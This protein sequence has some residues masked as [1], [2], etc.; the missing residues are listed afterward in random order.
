MGKKITFAKKALIDLKCIC[1]PWFY[2]AP[3]PPPSPPGNV[4]LKT[5]AE[6]VL[7]ALTFWWKNEK[8]PS[9]LIELD[10]EAGNLVV[11]LL[12]LLNY[13]YIFVLFVL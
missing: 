1:R 5:I 4:L 10:F 7:F 12:S 6:K 11:D 3:T 8:Q 9:G 13:F 2:F